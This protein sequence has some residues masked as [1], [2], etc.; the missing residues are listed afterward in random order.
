M[1]RYGLCLALGLSCG[2]AAADYSAHPKAGELL[3]T[4][5]SDYAFDVDALKTVRSALVQAERVDKLIE[6]ERTAPERTWTWYDY[7]P[8]HVNPKNI[9]NGRAFVEKHRSTFDAAE[10]R[11]GV[12][13]PVVAAI[14]GAETKYGG[15]TG[16]HRILDSLATQ[17]F[18]HPTRSRFFYS[19]LVQYFVL[20]RELGMNPTEPKGSYAGAMGLS[21]FMP[22][23]YRKLAVDFDDSGDVDLWTVD[24]AI[25]STANYLV[26]YRGAGKGWRRGEAV[27][28]AARVSEPLPKSVKTNTKFT[29]STIGKLA[30]AGIRPTIPLADDTPAGVIALEVAPGQMGYWIGLQNF[31]ALMSYNPRTFYAM[32]VFELSEAIANHDAP[33]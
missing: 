14:M 5:R 15:Y 29:S 9:E 7:R 32:S 1:I 28:V 26:N 33:R 25:G 8:I 11:W 30:E 4:L 27:L 16:P 12:P 2:S 10:Q 19:E 24:D 3:E 18:D 31:Y 23:N 13:G 17:G 22:S 6:Q 20:C 21:Q